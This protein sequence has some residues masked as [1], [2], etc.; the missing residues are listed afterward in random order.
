MTVPPLGNGHGPDH[1][2]SLISTLR[3]RGG[4]AA[5][6]AHCH[7]EIPTVS[8]VGLTVFALSSRR[9][10]LGTSGP[11]IDQIEDL[12]ISLDQGPCVN[13]VGDGT[14]VLV[15]DLAS[16]DATRRWPRFAAQALRRGVAAM[17]A[18]PV[19]VDAWPVAV[20]DLCRTTPGPLSEDDR[21][22]AM[23]YASA[24][25]V[26]METTSTLA[27]NSAGAAVSV[28]V[29]RTQ[30]ATG[31]V[32]GQATADATTALHQLRTNAFDRDLPL[33]AVVD[34]VLAG[35][36]RFDPPPADELSR[37]GGA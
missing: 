8:G 22:L 5:L 28:E 23:T 20:L 33:A 1:L 31:M 19:L 16:A 12:Q 9:F 35:R 15:D 18:F 29:A 17:F 11:L 27:Y 26:L 13:A 25:A 36:L 14:P 34:E 37:A 30:Q 10:V 21:R 7:T 6:C 2:A 3:D 4:T 32:M 24:A